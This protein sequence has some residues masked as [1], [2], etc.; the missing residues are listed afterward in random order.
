MTRKQTL[1]DAM[2]HHAAVQS[3]GDIVA[4]NVDV[5]EAMYNEDALIVA[6]MARTGKPRDVVVTWLKSK[7]GLDRVLIAAFL[8]GKL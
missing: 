8:G 6:V 3:L 7:S 1:A 2:A 5:T 4:P